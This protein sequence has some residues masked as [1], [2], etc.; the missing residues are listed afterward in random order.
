MKQ[1]I[2]TADKTA[3]VLVTIVIAVLYFTQQ[4]SGPTAIILLILASIFILTSL[5]GFCP[6]YLSFGIS[7]YRKKS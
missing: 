6:L 5:I 3:R 4:I 7:T 1:N 2:G